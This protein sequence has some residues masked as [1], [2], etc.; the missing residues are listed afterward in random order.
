M[1]QC[2]C[3]SS[4][5]HKCLHKYFVYEFSQLFAVAFCRSVSAWVSRKPTSGWWLT[6]VKPNPANR[7]CNDM[8]DLIK[9]V[10]EMKYKLNP[11]SSK[12][13]IYRNVFRIFTRGNFVFPMILP[14]FS[15]SDNLSITERKI[16]SNQKNFWS[17]I[18]GVFLLLLAFLYSWCHSEKDMKLNCHGTE[19]QFSH[20]LW[21]IGKKSIERK[22]ENTLRQT[23]KNSIGK[24]FDYSRFSWNN[25]FFFLFS[26]SSWLLRL[27]ALW[28]LDVDEVFL[29]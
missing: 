20:S 3:F 23:K 18:L 4:L 26:Y 27:L 6:R 9:C 17:S 5:T 15:V 1:C 24:Y 25:F 22:E 19:F 7:K 16:I 13:Q 14:L 29:F 8:I 11:F 12:I 10:S 28:Q 21:Q 2:A